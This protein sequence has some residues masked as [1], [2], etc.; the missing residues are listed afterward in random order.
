MNIYC[1]LNFIKETKIDNSIESLD[2]NSAINKKNISIEKIY[3]TAL[4]FSY[5]KSSIINKISYVFNIFSN[6]EGYI[7][8]NETIFTFFFIIICL[9]TNSGLSSIKSV[10]EIYKSV[11]KIRDQ[12]YFYLSSLY[13][14]D[15]LLNLTMTFINDLFSIANDALSSIYTNN[16][17]ISKFQNS[18]Y[19]SKRNSLQ[20]LLHMR[21]LI[22]D[23]ELSYS[24][25]NFELCNDIKLDKKNYCEKI[26]KN[27]FNWIFTNDGIRSKILQKEG[28]GKIY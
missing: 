13:N 16:L 21:S 3:L 12:D 6:E 9:S 11:T 4:G 27:N 14:L 5:C 2:I 19:N 20:V 18:T 22:S 25:K 15:K 1:L 7:E 24:Y 23:E 8:F 26:V 17:I 10:T 28:N